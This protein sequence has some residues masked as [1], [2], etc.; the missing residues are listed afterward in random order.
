MKENDFLKYKPVQKFVAGA[1]KAI[2]EFL[3]KD[4]GCIV[5]LGDDGFFYGKGLYQWLLNQGC[6]VV[7][8]F[9]DDGGEGLEEE[10]VR[11]RK[12]LIVDNDIVSGR[13]YKRAME[14][15]R[16]RKEE[17]KLQDIRFAVLCDRTGLADFSVEGY[18]GYA[19]WSLKELDGIDLKIIRE[20]SKD[21]RESLVKI[22]KKIGLSPVGVKNR[23][24]K[25]QKQDILKVQGLLSL[26]K[27]YSVSAQIEIEANQET[28]SSLAERFEKSP[29][30]YHLIKSSGRYNL[31]IGI[32]APNLATIED[33]IAK[34]I[35]AN[36]GVKHLEVNVGDLPIIPKTW[37]PPLA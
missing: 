4:K 31:V 5:A 26:D 19:P 6:K 30:V 16:S 27:F 32:T 10:K 7:L 34:E 12:V 18:S 35:R 29:L 9:M 23:V 3:G 37:N 8:T 24:E 20:L 21:G 15:L 28:V 17:L 14:V 22:A 1:G 33:F 13:G 11:D 2:K 36:P 25:L